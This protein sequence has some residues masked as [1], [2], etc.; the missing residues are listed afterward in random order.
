MSLIKEDVFQN[1]RDLPEHYRLCRQLFDFFSQ[2]EGITA[3][4][5][6]GSGVTGGMDSYSDLDL[7]FVCESDKAKE[8]IWSQR[9]DWKLPPWFHRMDADH[10]KPYFIIYLFEPEIHVDL[11]FYTI[12]NLPSK[13]GGPYAIA[14]DPRSQLNAW[15][16]E[17]NRSSVAAPD[18]SN[19][20]HEE[21][22]MWTWIHYAWCHAGRGES[23]DIA[24]EFWFLRNIPHSWFARLKGQS[25]F[26]SRRL[27]QK[28]EMEFIESMKL[29]Y[30]MPNRSS[31]KA[32][33]L[34]LIA[35]HNAQRA[36]VDRLLSPKW[37]TTQAARDKITRLVQEM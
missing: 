17:M 31:V 13:T 1:M 32:A 20:I 15:V 12:D 22:R 7:G 24:A 33:L 27:E 19:V 6:S 37:K 14:Y 29:C 4:F 25:Q 2:Q 30:P 35:V 34:S 26:S 36:Q 11:C 5:M 9:F 28:G 16:Q 10:V 8:K 18:W 23:Y 3:M 21:E